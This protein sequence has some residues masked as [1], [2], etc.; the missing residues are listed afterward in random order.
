MSVCQQAQTAKPTPEI[1]QDIWPVFKINTQAN[2]RKLEEEGILEMFIYCKEMHP[3]TWINGSTLFVSR[4]IETFR[5][6]KMDKS[7]IIN[8]VG[9]FYLQKVLTQQELASSSSAADIDLELPILPPVP[10][11]G[12]VRHE[13]LYSAQLLPFVK[14]ALRS[15]FRAIYVELLLY[16]NYSKFY[17]KRL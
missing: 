4:R 7:K 10:G 14:L 8:F 3:T 2:K 17:V 15:F 16:K 9:L 5:N 6:L 11:K 1:F 12:R 13:P